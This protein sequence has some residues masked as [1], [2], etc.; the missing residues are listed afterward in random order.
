MTK[1]LVLLMTMLLILGA[2]VSNKQFSEEKQSRDAELE[3]AKLEIDR[4]RRSIEELIMQLNEV[5]AQLSAL[6]TMQTQIDATAASVSH[7][8]AELADVNYRLYES[9]DGSVKPDRPRRF[10]PPEGDQHF[11]EYM[12]LLERMKDESAYFATK[13][14][15]TLLAE[16]CTQL[17]Q[18]LRDLANQVQ[19]IAATMSGVDVAGTGDRYTQQS[20]LSGILGRL[21]SL[22]ADLEAAKADIRSAREEQK[23]GLDSIRE[24]VVQVSGGLTEL[25]TDLG[26]EIVRQV[27]TL[28]PER[29]HAMNKRYQVALA[30]YYK[31]N[32]ERSILLFEEFLQLYPEGE[33][34]PN[35]H[36]WIGENYYAAENYAKA[37]RQFQAVADGWPRHKKAWDA[38]L[39]VGMTQYRLGN[40]SAATDVLIKLKT[41]Y[42]AYPQMKV[43]DKYLYRSRQ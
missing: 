8:E 2:C 5:Y 12:Q 29:A 13:Y 42:P 14:E 28:D 19:A 9:L 21:T 4:N 22:E 39:K 31:R 3:S 41:D 38:L 25:T 32:H 6:S 20:V 34:T 33:L 17:A 15:L 35:A 40:N 1:F 23:A 37:L 30:E 16:E 26:E 27:Q 11:E 10:V 7:M 36:Y 43:V 18:T 24:R